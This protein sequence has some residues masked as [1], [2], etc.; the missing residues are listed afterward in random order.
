MFDLRNFTDFSTS[1]DLKSIGISLSTEDLELQTREDDSW[2]DIYYKDK[3]HLSRTPPAA[4][5]SNNSSNMGWWHQDLI[6]KYIEG[7]IWVLNYYHH[8][9]I[10]WG[11]FFPYHYCPLGSDLQNLVEISKKIRFEM[12]IPFT[13]FLQLLAVL[14]PESSALVPPVYRPLMLDPN[15]PLADFYPRN[16][17]LDMN[18]KKNDWEAVVLIPFVDQV[19]NFFFF[20]FKIIFFFFP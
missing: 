13:P 3:F 18:D 4:Q 9:C 10:S 11:W 8:G 17:E 6:L 14:P 20:F 7:L 2:K 15:S 5:N 1:S 12:G 16:F 19:G